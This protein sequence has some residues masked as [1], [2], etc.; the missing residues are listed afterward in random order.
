MVEEKSWQSMAGH[1][2]S[3]IGAKLIKEAQGFCRY[4]LD[5]NLEIF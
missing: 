1:I 3:M 4:C 2:Q 5:L